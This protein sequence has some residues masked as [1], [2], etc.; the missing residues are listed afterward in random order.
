MH[1]IKPFWNSKSKSEYSMKSIKNEQFEA[2]L[3]IRTI[4]SF[5][6]IR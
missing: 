4:T 1:R 3:A 2:N 5:Y 6:D